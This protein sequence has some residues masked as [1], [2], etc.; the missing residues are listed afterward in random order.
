MVSK[1]GK[2]QT[3]S[4]K[5]KQC[6]LWQQNDRVI[7]LELFHSI[8]Q[9]YDQICMLLKYPALFVSVADSCGPR[10]PHPV[11]SFASPEVFG[12]KEPTVWASQRK[13][14]TDSSVSLGFIST[15]FPQPCLQSGQRQRDQPTKPD[16]ETCPQVDMK[17]CPK[18]PPVVT[19]IGYQHFTILL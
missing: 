4:K 16:R 14:Q 18:I 9:K 1:T 6:M 12:A 19:D 17:L 3:T 13:A 11:H 2:S 8:T 7:G 15:S 5:C 10:K